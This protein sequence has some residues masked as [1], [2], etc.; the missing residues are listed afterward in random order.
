MK[1]NYIVKRI[2]SPFD[3]T[4]FF[5]RNLH[6]KDAFLLDCGR[7]GDITNSELSDVK[8]IFISHTHI[9]HFYGFDRVIRGLL[10]SEK[11]IRLY[12]PPG[13]TKNVEGK[14][15][16]YTWNLIK[17]YPLTIEVY[18]IGYD[19]ICKTIFSARD[20]FNAVQCGYIEGDIYIDEGFVVQYCF[21]DHKTVSLG[22]R[23]K[24]PNYITINKEKLEGIGLKSGKW[25]GLLKEKL[26]NGDRDSD[27]F[28]EEVNRYFP[29]A[30]L[31]RLI[32]EYQKPQDITYITDI[33]PTYENFDKAIK[34]AKN[35]HLLII[36]SM[37]M[38]S[39]FMHSIEK[40]HLNIS[41]AKTIYEIS[42]SNFVKFFHF[43]PKYENCKGDFYNELRS[44]IEEKII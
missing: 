16:G 24:E 13:F 26:Y 7:L 39:D 3:D 35:S 25:I 21:F 41:L 1:H 18:E 30:E 32:V 33:A 15:A 6:K 22:Y 12:G 28:V 40:S 11:P 37:F 44:G 36:E 10:R 19:N 43:A 17:S 38:K 5:V 4:A 20:G 29:V 9:D 23:I 31:E 8:D 34:F 2:N 42:E 27:I 14:L